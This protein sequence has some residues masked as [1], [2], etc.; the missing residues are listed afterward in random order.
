VQF[1]ASKRTARNDE[2]KGMHPIYYEFS[3][4]WY[5]YMT[6]EFYDIQSAVE[7]R[8]LV[9]KMGYSDAFVVAYYNGFRITVA[10]AR[11]VISQNPELI[12]DAKKV[13]VKTDYVNTSTESMQSSSSFETTMMN[14]LD[15]LF[16]V[17]QI[18]VYGG[19]RSS[20]QLFGITPL[21]YDRLNNGY[22]RYFS[23]TYSSYEQA[24]DSQTRIRNLGVSDAFI[25]AYRNGKR[26]SVSEARRLIAEGERT[27]ETSTRT[28]TEDITPVKID[29]KTT[30]ST[31]M[32]N[33]NEI[34]KNL[35]ERAKN[36]SFRVQ[37]GAYRNNVPVDVLNSFI[38]I[39]DLNIQVITTD[40]GLNIYTAGNYNNMEEAGALKQ[41]VQNAGIDDAF[42]IAVENNKKI[43]IDEAKRILNLR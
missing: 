3:N 16:F 37:L 8:S 12:A 21:I 18:G 27:V 34:E 28:T 22:Y 1:S 9:Q 24:V 32:E 10:E 5:R 20:E 26:I 41:R 13:T 25:V 31:T 15:G 7:H 33:K 40:D 2:Y 17:V 42:V 30:E 6:G 14:D 43:T 35:P 4:D 39:P 19:A 23:G 36:I 38:T 11:N 29:N